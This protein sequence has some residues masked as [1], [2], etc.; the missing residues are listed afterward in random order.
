MTLASD[1]ANKMIEKGFTELRPWSSKNYFGIERIYW[2][3]CPGYIELSG[4]YGFRVEGTNIP[5]TIINATKSTLIEW[6]N[7]KIINY[8]EDEGLPF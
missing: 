2:S 8:Y 4:R 5:E 3:N 6:K 7:S 1:I